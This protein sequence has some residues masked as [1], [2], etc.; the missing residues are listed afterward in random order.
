MSES[1]I[2]VKLMQKLKEDEERLKKESAM[3]AASYG[4]NKE[5]QQAIKA[6]ILEAE[7]EEA[8]LKDAEAEAAEDAAEDAAKPIL[9]SPPVPPHSPAKTYRTPLKKSSRAR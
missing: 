2:L 4:Y 6:L 3:I 9:P 8:K 5:L 1:T 7:A